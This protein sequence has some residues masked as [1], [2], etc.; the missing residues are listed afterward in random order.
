MSTTDATTDGGIQ[1]VFDEVSRAWGVGDAD[2]FAEWYA[3]D[4]TAVLPGSYLQDRE[5]IRAAMAVAFAGPLHGSGRVHAVQKVR[6]L[7]DDTAIV[8]TRSST[9]S[10]GGGEPPVER[11]ELAT[12]VLSRQDGRWLIRAYHGCPEDAASASTRRNHNG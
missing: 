7:G 11:R 10:A 12:W 1:E 6:F 4:A 8:I 3:E 2:K 5:A 9:L